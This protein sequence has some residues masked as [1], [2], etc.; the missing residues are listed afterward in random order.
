[1]CVSRKYITV[2]VGAQNGDTIFLWRVDQRPLFYMRRGLEKGFQFYSSGRVRICKCTTSKAN[3][4]P[5]G[6]LGLLDGFPVCYCLLPF[7]GHIIYNSVFNYLY[8]HGQELFYK[9]FSKITNKLVKQL[10]SMTV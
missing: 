10:L 5:H 8:S 4:E 3:S 9:F 7:F 1:M 6:T 2:S